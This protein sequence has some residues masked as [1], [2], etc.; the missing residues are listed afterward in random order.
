[1]NHSIGLTDQPWLFDRG[2][3][4]W[5]ERE[6]VRGFIELSSITLQNY[7]HFRHYTYCSE[8]FQN[9][10]R[11]G[12]R[13]KAYEAGEVN[14]IDGTHIIRNTSFRRMAQFIK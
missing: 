5:R 1:M 14:L 2:S 8:M 7:R 12:E 6:R 13:E 11:T 4:Y 3:G 9:V 10:N